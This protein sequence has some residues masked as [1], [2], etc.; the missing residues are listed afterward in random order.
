MAPSIF[1]E[2]P[3]VNEVIVPL[4]KTERTKELTN[5]RPISI[6]TCFSKIFEKLI[7]SR[8]ISFFK[9]TP[10]YTTRSMDF[11]MACQQLMLY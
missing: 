9:K 8:L 6:L 2:P 3:R 4:F 1:L 5:Y 10:F 11:E 7:Y